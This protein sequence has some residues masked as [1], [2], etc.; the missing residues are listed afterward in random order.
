MHLLR[1]LLHWNLSSN[2]MLFLKLS[3]LFILLLWFE[4]CGNNLIF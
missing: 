4:N 2:K 1:D 3:E